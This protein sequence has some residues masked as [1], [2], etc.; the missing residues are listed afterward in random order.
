MMAVTSANDFLAQLYASN[1]QLKA[2]ADA[3]NARTAGVNFLADQL[4]GQASQYGFSWKVN[5]RPAKNHQQAMAKILYDKGVRNLSDLG[6]SKDGKNLI[7]KTNGQIV[8]W[9][10]DNTMDKNGRAQIGWNAEGRGRTNYYVYKDA[11]GNPVVAPQWRSNAPGGIGGALLKYAAPVISVF[12]PLAGAAIGA[13]LGLA[14]GQ[15]FG[16]IAKGAALNYG[17]SSLGGRLSNL[18]TGSLPMIGN[19]GIT[20]AIADAAGAAGAGGIRGIV[21]GQNPLRSALIGGA[22]G[23]IGSGIGQLMGQMPSTGNDKFDQFLQSAAGSGLRGMINP[24]IAGLFSGSGSSGGANTGQGNPQQGGNANTNALLAGMM[25]GGINQ[26]QPGQ[27][28]VR[29]Q[30][31][32]SPKLSFV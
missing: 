30:M 24:E 8:P 10:K 19:A 17:L 18:A 31:G 32:D 12:N 2:K 13:G 15:K 22:T 29:Y 7:N 6:Y 23:A 28:Q 1:P 5:N 26:Q 4:G 11:N 9:Y 16:D 20:N 3:A 27:Q 14:Q 21:T 25:L